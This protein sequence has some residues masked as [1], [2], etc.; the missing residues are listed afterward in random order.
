VPLQDG[1]TPRGSQSAN[2]HGR[3]L[4]PHPQQA[5]RARR[6]CRRPGHVGTMSREYFPARL[7]L[8]YVYE[9]RLFIKEAKADALTDMHSGKAYP[10]GY[11][12]D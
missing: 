10:A 7:R 3:Q 6:P 12:K 1:L 4:H 9:R 8:F 5:F 11:F 2:Q